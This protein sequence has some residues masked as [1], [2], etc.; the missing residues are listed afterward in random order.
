[1][2]AVTSEVSG[3][4]PQVHGHVKWVIEGS[5]LKLEGFAFYGGDAVAS[6]SDTTTLTMTICKCEIGLC[7]KL[8]LV[9][10]E[11]TGTFTV[12]SG[13][14]YTVRMSNYDLWSVKLAF[15]LPTAGVGRVNTFTYKIQHGIELAGHPRITGH[16]TK[17]QQFAPAFLFSINR[18]LPELSIAVGPRSTMLM[19]N[20]IVKIGKEELPTQ[21]PNGRAFWPAQSSGYASR[22][23]L[24]RVMYDKFARRFVVLQLRELALPNPDFIIYTASELLFAVSRCS[25]P[26]LAE[27]D[28]CKFVF[29]AYVPTPIPVPPDTLLKTTNAI[30]LS[31]DT[32]YYYVGNTFFSII[33]HVENDGVTV[34]AIKKDQIRCSEPLPAEEVLSLP[35]PSDLYPGNYSYFTL[36]QML[37]ARDYVY[38]IFHIDGEPFTIYHISGDRI[39]KKILPV[40][41]SGLG[42]GTAVYRN[43][44][45][46]FTYE[47]SQSSIIW[48]E[49]AAKTLE[50]LQSQN[51]TSLTS[52]LRTP[53][54]M[55]S[56]NESMFLTLSIAEENIWSLG[57]TFRLAQDVPGTTRDVSVASQG[58]QVVESPTRD[59]QFTSSSCMGVCDEETM[60]SFG[61]YTERKGNWK[62]TVIKFD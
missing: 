11:S 27:K 30:T 49:I 39:R 57:Y 25:N 16:N 45:I 50:I 28:W 44:K 47:V 62:S 35:V 56:K 52:K 59:D 14:S 32:N 13:D 38:A 31:Y 24:N 48:F 51:I 8:R 3:P 29:A 61:G 43:R 23:R 42:K 20:G 22:P 55:V 37:D 1:M 2:F 12:H 33:D 46:W 15:E 19:S 9:A 34:Y 17:I 40:A 5:I 60:Y 7:K 36:V 58:L 10:G 6:T 18:I 21:H 54:I 4:P 41:L 26:S 53:S